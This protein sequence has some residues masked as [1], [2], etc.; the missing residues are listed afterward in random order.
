MPAPGRAPMT[1][2]SDGSNRRADGLSSAGTCRRTSTAPP[3]APSVVLGCV[4]CNRACSS[5]YEV[6]PLRRRT[7]SA[8]RRGRAARDVVTASRWRTEPFRV[9]FPLGVLLA[10]IGVG[11]WLLYALGVTA[12]YSCQLHGLIQMQAFM[13]AFAHGILWTAVP[14]RTGTAPASAAEM[15]GAAFALVVTAAAATTE[16]WIVAELAYAALLVLLLAFAV[17]RLVTRGARWRSQANFVRLPLGI[18][19]GLS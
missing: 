16:R 9:F 5:R 4:P 7:L 11:H 3:L 17:R 18:L 1:A 8:L 2:V 14:R 6:R 15:A 13:M 10:W 12:T 19:H